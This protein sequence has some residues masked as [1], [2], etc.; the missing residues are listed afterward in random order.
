MAYKERQRLTT[1]T[2]TQLDTPYTASAA[3]E[4]I[5]VDATLGVVT[6]NLPSASAIPAGCGIIVK[7]KDATVSVVTVAATGGQTID[8]LASRPLAMQWD[9]LSLVTDGSAWFRVGGIP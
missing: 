8:G 6:V 7:K 9:A 4:L 5:I 1:R 3:D 2:I